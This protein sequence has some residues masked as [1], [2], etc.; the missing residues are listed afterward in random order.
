MRSVLSLRRLRGV[1]AWFLLALVCT[2]AAPVEAASSSAA[3]G[4]V[5]LV[6]SGGGARGFAHIGALKALQQLHVP[7]DCIAGTS[8]GAIIGGL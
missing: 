4:R 1:L 8:M 6:L 5:C 2:A 7:I 3:N